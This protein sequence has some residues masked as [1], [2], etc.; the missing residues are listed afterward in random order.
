LLRSAAIP[1]PKGAAT[2]IHDFYL[3]IQNYRRGDLPLMSGRIR[4]FIT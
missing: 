4:D 1:L 2:G 3:F